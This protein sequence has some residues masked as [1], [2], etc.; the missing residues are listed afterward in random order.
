MIRS[1]LRALALAVGLL[2][3]AAA[4]A[5]IDEADAA[6]TDAFRDAARAVPSPEVRGI[7]SMGMGDAFVGGGG[8]VSAVYS[9]PA[10]VISGAVYEGAATYIRSFG[11]DLNSLGVSLV[12]AKTNSSLAAGF[13]YSLG[14]GENAALQDLFDANAEVVSSTRARIV[15]HDIHGVIALPVVPQRLS[16]GAGVH[17]YRHARGRWT[18]TVTERTE[19]GTDG[20]TT[21][22]LDDVDENYAVDDRG[23]T[24]D[25]G[26]LALASDQFSL[27]FSVANLLNHEEIAGGRTFR[28][29]AALFLE[30]VHIEAEW[31]AST[32]A[33]GGLEHGAAV[34]LEAVIQQ[35]PLRVGF[36][37]QNTDAMFLALG[38][39]FRAD[40]FG[41]DL[42]F[43]Q[44]V[45]ASADRRFGF[46][47]SLFL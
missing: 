34:G 23:I 36:R 40:R 16:L 3:P 13:G 14:L 24:L 22:S 12:D 18:Q 29:G 37:Y 38:G 17:Y 6:L 1:G 39:G 44:N 45:R 32:L 5:Q 30:S 26:V 2:S 21:V 4:V 42:A 20:Q 9:N 27:G 25:A 46:S 28:G 41:G 19:R 8:G 10:A 11:S 31:R 15:D 33:D 35:A 7:R 43:E 47:M